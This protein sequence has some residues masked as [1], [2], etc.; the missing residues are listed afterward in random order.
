MLILIGMSLLYGGND[1]DVCVVVVVE[2][3]EY[4]ESS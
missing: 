1:V 2:D 3:E 4:E